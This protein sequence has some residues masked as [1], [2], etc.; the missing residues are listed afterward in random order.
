MSASV[1]RLRAAVE[2][3]DEVCCNTS[4]NEQLRAW[5]E[6]ASAVDAVA[7]EIDRLTRERDGAIALRDDAWREAARTATDLNDGSEFW[8][9]GV[10]I[11]R[12]AIERA[13]F[14]LSAFYAS[15]VAAQIRSA[16]E[17]ASRKAEQP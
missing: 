6:L 3:F 14:D 16:Q 10:R 11:S 5:N 1:E 15:E 2:E 7:A 9:L 4:S 13:G 12:E 17:Y 8:T